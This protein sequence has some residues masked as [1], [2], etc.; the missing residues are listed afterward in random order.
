MIIKEYSAKL[1]RDCNFYTF[2][3]MKKR[4]LNVIVLSSILTIMASETNAQQQKK[5]V[6]NKII[7]A[8]STTQK[9]EPA[10][11]SD[12]TISKNQ[13]AGDTTIVFNQDERI[14]QL[15]ERYDKLHK[16]GMINGY[17]IELF[18]SSGANSKAK[19]FEAMLDFKE[20]YPDALAYVVWENPNFEL[21]IG[22]FRTRLEAMK[23][24]QEISKDYPFAFIK[25][26]KINL[27]P[28]GETKKAED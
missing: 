8:E 13:D 18:S 17:R 7:S 11:H 15:Q 22:D 5:F 23:Q 24:L 4:T 28:L 25:K 3:F 9:L 21:E 2:A 16:D 1:N 10:V 20:K 14:D 12:S 27:P 26:T 19:A 6:S